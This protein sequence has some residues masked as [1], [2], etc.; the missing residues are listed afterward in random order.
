MHHGA[1][2]GGGL[3]AGEWRVDFFHASWG[4]IVS[5]GRWQPSISHWK[6]GGYAWIYDGNWYW[7]SPPPERPR[8]GGLHNII[9]GI[10]KLGAPGF[11]RNNVAQQVRKF[12]PRGINN[13]GLALLL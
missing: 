3:G 1:L 9:G 11:F 4:D 6:R 13:T 10:L 2:I 5:T 7:T 12:Y 8:R